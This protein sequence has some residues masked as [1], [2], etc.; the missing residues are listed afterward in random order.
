LI[1][2]TWAKK[3]LLTYGTGDN[4]V[5]SMLKQITEEGQDDSSNTITL[6]ATSETYAT[7]SLKWT[8]VD[9]NTQWSGGND[10]GSGLTYIDVNGDGLTDYVY[11]VSGQP[12]QVYINNGSKFVLDSNWHVPGALNQTT[13]AGNRVADING[14]GLPDFIY[15]YNNNG[16]AS[17][18]VW[19]NNGADWVQDTSWSSL[20][21]AFA[22]ISGGAAGSCGMELV[23][24]N[25]D[26]LPDLI[27]ASPTSFC[28]GSFGQYINTGHGWVGTS[29]WSSCAGGAGSGVTYIDVNGDGLTDCVNVNGISQVN[30]NTGTGFTGDTG[31]HLPGPVNLSSNDQGY[32]FGDVNGDGL[33][34]VVQSVAVWNGISAYYSSSTIFYNTGSDWSKS[35]AASGT[36]PISAN[37]SGAFLVNTGVNGTAYLLASWE[38][39]GTGPVHSWDAASLEHMRTGSPPHMRNGVIEADYPCQVN[40]PW[41]NPGAPPSVTPPPITDP[42]PTSPSGSAGSIYKGGA[43]LQDLAMYTTPSH[44]D[45]LLHASIR[46]YINLQFQDALEKLIFLKAIVSTKVRSSPP[47]TGRDLIRYQASGDKVD[48]LIR[49]LS[50]N[51]DY[52]AQ[53]LNH[54]PRLSV[55]DYISSL[56]GLIQYCKDI[57]QYYLSY[58]NLEKAQESGVTKFSAARSKALAAIA[59][60]QAQIPGLV[61]QQNGTLE[62]IARLELALTDLWAQL[63]SADQIFKQAV[64]SHGHGCKFEQVVAIGAAIATIVASGGTAAAMIPVA[65]SALRKEP[66]KYDNGSSV[67]D[68]FKGFKYK[69]DAVVTVGKDAVSILD[70][71][72]KL[73]GSFA[74]PPPGP[75]LPNLPG[76]EAKI[77]ASAK[78]IDEE[79]RPFLVMKEA[80]N[81]QTLIRAFVATAEARNN[82]ILEYNTLQCQLQSLNSDIQQ[83]QVGA[84]AAQDAVAS[85]ANPFLG[86]AVSYM[87]GAWMRSMNAIVRV[88]YQMQRA[89]KYYALDDPPITIQDFSIGALEASALNLLALYKQKMEEFGGEP[90]SISGFEINVFPYVSSE[91]LRKFRQTGKLTVA[92]DVN[93]HELSRYSNVYV[94]RVWLKLEDNTGPL[95]TFQA[96][97]THEGRALVFNSQRRL[98]TFSHTPVPIGYQVKNGIDIV[99]GN[100]AK[101][102]I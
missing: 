45:M 83:A 57:E 76:D 98:F 9:T 71:Y 40:S 78:Q 84:D 47:P 59:S 60:V 73:K 75:A 100:I 13:D 61:D 46:D 35:T 42:V 68:D 2:G 1:S 82:K 51:L 62:S 87:T 58:K 23:D 94:T 65:L 6:P 38:V 15:S 70:A 36:M 72:N 101:A 24:L 5:R 10:G 53:P 93:E 90:Q 34:D 30:I 20:P 18:S 27:G 56:N 50:L 22:Y 32:R 91:S 11:T 81:Y 12:K 8:S 66:L 31:W 44:V 77:V 88:I 28:G 43:T 33:P 29:N 19:I 89:Y 26:G 21:S 7:S 96:N 17:S 64:A 55:D 67:A 25:G 14:D 37:G 74:P 39:R 92:V 4:G 54:V 85:L 49:Q 99:H 3:Y 69:V 52:Y 80:Q 97:I 41:S 79:L 102:A 48:S 95:K 63:M 16:T 86:E